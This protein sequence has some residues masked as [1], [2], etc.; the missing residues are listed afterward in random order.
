MVSAQVIGHRST[1]YTNTNNKNSYIQA[2]DD[3]TVML[4]KREESSQRGRLNRVGAARQ[5]KELF[6][7]LR[8]IEFQLHEHGEVSPSGLDQLFL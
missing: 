4:E 5:G 8:S 2:I 1:H 3:K 7:S 6:K